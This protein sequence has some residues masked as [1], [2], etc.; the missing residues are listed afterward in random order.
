MKDRVAVSLDVSAPVLF[1]LLEFMGTDMDGECANMNARL[2]GGHLPW[3]VR[4]TEDAGGFVIHDKNWL[5]EERFPLPCGLAH[6]AESLR[7]RCEKTYSKMDFS[8]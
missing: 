1:R 4:V 3:S 8:P 7:S 6:V 5:S 2:V